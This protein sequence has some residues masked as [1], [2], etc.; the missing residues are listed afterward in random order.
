MMSNKY[1]LMIYFAHSTLVFYAKSIISNDKMSTG[2][3]M[4]ANQ[5]VITRVANEAKS[6]M[7]YELSYNQIACA[8]TAYQQAKYFPQSIQDTKPYQ[9]E[10]P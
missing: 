1:R 7:K 10:T 6:V 4:A 3:F 2:D 9:P 5:D 8:C